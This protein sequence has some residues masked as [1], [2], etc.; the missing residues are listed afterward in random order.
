MSENNV[1][2]DVKELPLPPDN[3]IEE[4]IVVPAAPEDKESKS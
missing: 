4:G 3:P 1:V 2:K